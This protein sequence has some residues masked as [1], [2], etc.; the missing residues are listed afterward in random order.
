MVWGHWI[1]PY[2]AQGLFLAG[3]P[4]VIHRGT[5]CAVYY[6]NLYLCLNTRQVPKFR[7][8]SRTLI[9]LECEL[10]RSHT[11]CSGFTNSVLR[12]TPGG[13]QEDLFGSKNHTGKA[14]G[15]PSVLS[16]WLHQNYFIVLHFSMNTDQTYIIW[17]CA[18]I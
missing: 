1:T 13:T 18:G 9:L 4:Y 2:C 11:I 10:G 15:L 16:L 7:Y 17:H 5:L 14:N 12:I 6:S 3:E 8:S